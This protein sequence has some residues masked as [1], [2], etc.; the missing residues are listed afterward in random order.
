MIQT[1]QTHLRRAK[2]HILSAHF[3]P[4]AGNFFLIHL[5]SFFLLSLGMEPLGW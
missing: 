1:M 4:N 3:N 5:F 2:K